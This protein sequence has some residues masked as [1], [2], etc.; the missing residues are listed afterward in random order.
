MKRG[1]YEDKQ[2]LAL[3]TGFFSSAVTLLNLWLT[4]AA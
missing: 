1:W 2:N 4:L 3:V